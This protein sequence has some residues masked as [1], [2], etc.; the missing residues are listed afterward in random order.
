MT[1][2]HHRAA[3]R[4]MSVALALALCFCLAGSAL[5]DSE[6]ITIFSQIADSEI[7]N[8][9][10]SPSMQELSRVT[11]VEVEWVHPPK[12]QE[13]EQFNLMVA[14]QDLND[15]IYYNWASYAGGPEKAI[16]DEVIIPLND[17]IDEYAPNLKAFFEKYPEAKRQCTTDEGTVY[18]FPFVRAVNLEADTA[19][20]NCT[21]GPIYRA[22]WAEKL[23]IAAPET[24]EDWYNMLCAFRDNDMNGN[25]DPSD[26]IPMTGLNGSSSQITINYF[27]AAFGVLEGFY[28]EDG[29]VNH[30]ILSPK[31]KEYLDT[32]R[33]WYAEGLIDPDYLLV[34][35]NTLQAKVTSGLAGSWFGS[36]TAHYATY[37]GI[38]AETVP[39]AKVAALNWPVTA[40]GKRY[41]A[42]PSVNAICNGKGFA[43]ST[44]CKDIPAAM[45]YL[46]YIYSDE[47]IRLVNYG[48]EGVHYTL[49]ADGSIVWTEAMQAE[50]N[51]KGFRSAVI[52]V[53]FG[54][55]SGYIY[56][57]AQLAMM[58]KTNPAQV[59]AVTVWG[60]A[61]AELLLPTLTPSA[62]ESAIYA[63]IMSQ[64]DTYLDEMV[65]KYIMGLIDASEYDAIVENCRK[66]GIEQVVAI[67]NAA[68]QRYLA[69]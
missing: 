52:P 21:Q 50:I 24:I 13:K 47:G 55:R 22:D 46:D 5:A 8:H 67:E 54:G 29:A 9:A 4:L 45:R 25:G 12:G 33:Q 44:A 17:Y 58:A 68:Y 62:E 36:E 48:V 64:V 37:I 10:D 23:G 40:D 53:A 56:Q 26:E 6:P 31:Y 35:A 14:S 18:M 11:G 60:Q 20:L 15:V 7:S 41:T 19:W 63:D 2:I 42:Q 57:D 43:I 16:S 34:D 66:M 69:R 49:G 65:G 51:E 61:S 27:A 38:M 28:L 3:S 39:E 32:M 59:E 30:A 1:R